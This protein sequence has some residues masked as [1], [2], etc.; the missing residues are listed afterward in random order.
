MQK[1]ST[2]ASAP[3]PSSLKVPAAIDVISSGHVRGA[4]LALTPGLGEAEDA[5]GGGCRFVSTGASFFEHAPSSKMRMAAR[6]CRPQ[7]WPPAPPQV[8]QVFSSLQ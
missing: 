8:L 6:I 7:R 2:R 5:V 4:A 3:A 1:A